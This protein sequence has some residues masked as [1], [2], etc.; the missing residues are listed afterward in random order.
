MVALG[1]EVGPVVQVRGDVVRSL[2]VQ[3][4]QFV[5]EGFC[6]FEIGYEDRWHGEFVARD[7]VNE[8][9]CGWVL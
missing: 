2:A 5:G 7:A 9:F 4:R 1:Q 3:I 6:D 8:Q